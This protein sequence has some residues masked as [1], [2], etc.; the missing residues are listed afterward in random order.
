MVV[1]AALAVVFYDE[2]SYEVSAATS[3]EADGA[4]LAVHLGSTRD[5]THAQLAIE[6]LLRV[7]VDDPA[8]ASQAVGE[9]EIVVGE[10]EDDAEWNLS[11]AYNR[12]E[13]AWVAYALTGT[14]SWEDVLAEVEAAEAIDPA[15]GVFSYWAA[16]NAAASGQ[17]GEALRLAERSADL[18]P[19]RQAEALLEALR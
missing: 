3:G 12:M 8:L 4:V 18:E 11:L 14:A 5:P 6:R 15:T 19:T 10:W 7:A 9:A 1:S 17:P 2:V 16:V 13:A